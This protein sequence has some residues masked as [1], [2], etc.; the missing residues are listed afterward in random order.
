M[1]MGEKSVRATISKELPSDASNSFRVPE[2]TGLLV[3]AKPAP[4]KKKKRPVLTNKQRAV[5]AREHY[6]LHHHTATPPPHLAH[7]ISPILSYSASPR[8]LARKLTTSLWKAT[9]SRTSFR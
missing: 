8:L 2:N 9:P 3:V 4:K 6:A 1:I 7:V 5:W